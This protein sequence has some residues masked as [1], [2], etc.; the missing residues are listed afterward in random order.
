MSY[1]SRL[2]LV[3]ES[4]IFDEEINLYWAQV[5]TVFDLGK[6]RAYENFN[7]LLDTS[8]DTDFFFYGIDGDTK[9]MTDHYNRKLKQFSIRELVEALDKDLDILK[10]NRFIDTSKIEK[11]NSY[12]TLFISNTE[13]H[14]IHY[15]Y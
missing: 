9:I 13:F 5:T 6:M 7:T 2:F 15:G 1:E 10:K 4:N 3:K 11:L 14:I 8:K 12:L